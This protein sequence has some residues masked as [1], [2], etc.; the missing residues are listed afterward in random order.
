MPPKSVP[1]VQVPVMAF[2][3]FGNPIPVLFG[4]VI[5]AKGMTVYD[6]KSSWKM[7]CPVE[8]L[9]RMGIDAAVAV[10]PTKRTD[11]NKAARAMTERRVVPKRLRD[12]RFM[13]FSDRFE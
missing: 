3:V 7:V 12:G 6:S 13:R 9:R 8:M 10:K 11:T 2:A 5:E 1:A 4:G